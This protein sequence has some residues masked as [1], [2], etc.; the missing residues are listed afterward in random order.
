MDTDC[1][2]KSVQLERRCRGWSLTLMLHG[3]LLSGC[4][5]SGCMHSVGRFPRVC[6][7][8][9]KWNFTGVFSRVA[10]SNLTYNWAQYTS[11]GPNTV[12]LFIQNKTS[13]GENVV[14]W[15]SLSYVLGHQTW[16]VDFSGFEFRNGF[17]VVSVAY[18]E[19]S[20]SLTSVMKGIC[21]VPIIPLIDFIHQN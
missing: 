3:P 14:G 9:F 21:P 7:R 2:C 18:G 4:C 1:P 6:R 10:L 19:A 17:F 12:A 15:K 11:R 5:E 16:K 8:S 13:Q 20:A